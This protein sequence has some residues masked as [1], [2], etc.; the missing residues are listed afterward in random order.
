MEILSYS[1]DN[2]TDLNLCWAQQIVKLD[3]KLLNK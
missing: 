3:L 1:V 2:K